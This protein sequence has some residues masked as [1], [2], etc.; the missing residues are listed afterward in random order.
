MKVHDAWLPLEQILSAYIDMAQCKKVVALP[1]SEVED[2]PCEEYAPWVLRA[3]SDETVHKALESFEA[4]I[5]SIEQRRPARRPQEDP[6]ELKYGLATGED[7]D[8]AC[9]FEPFAREFLQ[10]ARCPDFD[11]IAPGL[12]VLRN[13]D[14]CEQ[15][16]RGIDNRK[17]KNEGFAQA[18]LLFEGTGNATDGMDFPWNTSNPVPS[19]LYLYAETPWSSC[20][21]L[22][23]PFRLGNSGWAR[24]CE[25][26]YAGRRIPND[27]RRPRSEMYMPDF[28]LF[29]DAHRGT[30][31][32]V[33]F[34]NWRGMIERGIWEI[35]VNGVS[36]DI[37]KFKEADTE[38]TWKEYVLPPAW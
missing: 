4:L 20:G 13:N 15:P 16:L 8:L 25:A 24:S 30:R 21:V 9:I 22:K 6:P 32:E 1:R 18:V 5:D 38:E 23:L 10:R 33:I 31:L 29:I 7:L 27:E 26:L 37:S 12:C 19:G 2:K 35:D 36:A 34:N 11:F 28:N 3:W 17:H 14:I